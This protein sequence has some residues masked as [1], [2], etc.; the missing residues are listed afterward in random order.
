[1]DVGTNLESAGVA[2]LMFI[3][4]RTTGDTVSDFFIQGFAG[5]VASAAFDL[6]TP[7]EGP[8][9]DISVAIAEAAREGMS[10]VRISSC[11]FYHDNRCM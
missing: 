8:E 10:Q 11:T 3:H 4:V 9:H 2:E 1:M 6:Y 7:A 5:L